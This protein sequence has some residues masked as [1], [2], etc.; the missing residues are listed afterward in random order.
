M[1]TLIAFIKFCFNK[2]E[3]V[4]YETFSLI[5]AFPVELVKKDL[6]KM[7]QKINRKNAVFSDKKFLDS[8]FLPGGI[9]GKKKMFCLCKS[10]TIEL[11]DAPRWE[12]TQRSGLLGS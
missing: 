6:N 10:H 1:F 12:G 4:G 7:R 5:H 9:I 2:K 8:M 11:G 3:L